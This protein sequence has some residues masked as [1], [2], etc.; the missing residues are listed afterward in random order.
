LDSLLV[1]FVTALELFWLFRAEDA[2]LDSALADEVRADRVFF[3]DFES[4]EGVVDVGEV[5]VEVDVPGRFFVASNM[6]G[7][8]VGPE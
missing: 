4:E 6:N 7:G 2:T 3:E 8:L 1:G 5:D